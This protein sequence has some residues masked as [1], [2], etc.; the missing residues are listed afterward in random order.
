MPQYFTNISPI[1]Y[2][3]FTNISPIFH[4]YFTNISP[5]FHQYFTNISP[6]FH[7]YFTNILPIFHQYFTNISPIF[8]QYF[9]NIS[10]IF[11]Q[12]FTNISPIFHLI[13]EGLRVRKVGFSREQNRTWQIPQKAVHKRWHQ[14]CLQQITVLDVI[15]NNIVSLQW[16]RV[17][18][19]PRKLHGISSTSFLGF[20][21]SRHLTRIRVKCRER[22]NPR[23]EVRNSYFFI[24]W[25]WRK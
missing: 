15:G 24:F 4:Q 21:L 1:F 17:S 23:N 6:I 20:L 5:I 10:P 16:E 25:D 14:F 22:R 2:Q 11:H 18:Y 9:T 13:N 19:S 7:L 3:Y 8:H 12:Y